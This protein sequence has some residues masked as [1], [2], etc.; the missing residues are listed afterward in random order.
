MIRIL[1][2]TFVIGVTLGS[3]YA[4]DVTGSWRGQIM[5]PGSPLEVG[6]TFA[7]DAGGADALT[8]TIDI[9][10]QG[11]SELPLTNIKQ[12]GRTISFGLAGIPGEP[13]FEGE[14]SGT[15]AVRELVGTFL[16]GGQDFPLTLSPGQLENAARPQ[17]PEP[18]FPYRSEAAEVK[19][20]AVTLV[21]TL[22]LPEGKTAPSPLYS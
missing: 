1:W 20:S 8:G 17:E 3:A 7:E 15:G 10:V 21:G 14:L 13:R 11:I 18:P 22:T 5:I 2:C 6:L 4:Q 16:Q 19:S 9:P 12:E